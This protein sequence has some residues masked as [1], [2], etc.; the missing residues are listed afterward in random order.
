MASLWISSL[1]KYL[2]SLFFIQ[3]VWQSGVAYFYAEKANQ[4]QEN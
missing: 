3:L 2:T 1:V 4:G